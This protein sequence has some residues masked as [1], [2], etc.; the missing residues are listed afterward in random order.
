MRSEPHI[1]TLLEGFR[2]RA[3]FS[4]AVLIQHD[5]LI[6]WRKARIARVRADMKR[7]NRT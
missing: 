1:R 7:R 2:P 4:L 5:D 3:R 6:R